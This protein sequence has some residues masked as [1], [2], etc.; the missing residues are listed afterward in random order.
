MSQRATDTEFFNELVLSLELRESAQAMT[1]GQLAKHLVEEVWVNIR[2]KTWP[3]ALV[4]EAID[5]LRR[6]DIRRRWQERKE[7]RAQQGIDI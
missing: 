3:S 5:R 6:A 7:R 1:D 2:L 4:D